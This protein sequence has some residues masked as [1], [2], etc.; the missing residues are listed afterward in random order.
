MENKKRMMNLTPHPIKI[1]LDEEKVMQFPSEGIARVSEISETIGSLM[2]GQLPIVRK[3]FGDVIDLPAP[4]DGVGLIVS[5][6]VQ[7]ACHHRSDLFV[8]ADFVR[9]EQGKIV[10]CKSLMNNNFEVK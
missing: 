8:P 5:A 10:G 4:R 9:D 1:I 6:M 7:S 2:N 3:K